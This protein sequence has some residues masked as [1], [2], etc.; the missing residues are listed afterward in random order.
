MTINIFVLKGDL[1]GKIVVVR[2]FFCWVYDIGTKISRTGPFTCN[3][4]IH[5]FGMGISYARTQ[6]FVFQRGLHLTTF[7]IFICVF[8]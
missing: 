8:L 6:T 1:N 3:L 4:N 5:G 2:F 7:F